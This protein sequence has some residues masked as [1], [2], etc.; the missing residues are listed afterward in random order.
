LPARWSKAAFPAA[1]Q[2]AGAAAGVQLGAFAREVIFTAADGF[3]RGFS[4]NFGD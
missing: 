2:D 4:K 3:G 1:V